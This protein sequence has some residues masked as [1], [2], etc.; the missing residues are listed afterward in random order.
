MHFSFGFG[1]HRCVG[2]RLADMQLEILWEEIM[3]RYKNIK[4]KG[5]PESV[6]H[7]CCKEVIRSQLPVNQIME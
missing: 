1:I 7:I 6:N 5:E 3:K 2:N 4:E